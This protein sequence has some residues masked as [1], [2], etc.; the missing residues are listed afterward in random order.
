MKAKNASI[1]FD[2]GDE[3]RLPSLRCITSK[4]AE[5]PVYEVVD[6]RI[7]EGTGVADLSHAVMV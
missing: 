4:L 6:A 2:A 7:I 5:I 3:H 1:T